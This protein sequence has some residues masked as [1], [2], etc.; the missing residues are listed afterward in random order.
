MM[1]EIGHHKLTDGDNGSGMV[2]NH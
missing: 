1:E 2:Q